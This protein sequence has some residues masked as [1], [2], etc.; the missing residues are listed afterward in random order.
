MRYLIGSKPGGGYDRY[1]RLVAKHLE[2]ELEGSRFIPENRGS[3]NGILALREVHDA[4][5]D[6]DILLI[7]NTGLLL[8]ELGGQDGMDMSLADFNWIGKASSE[9]RILLVRKGTGISSF[10]ELRQRGEGLIFVTSGFGGASNVQTTMINTTFGLGVKVVPGFGGNEAEAAL[11]KDEVDG[12]LMSESNVPQLLEADAA[13]PLLA[14]GRS[15][16]PGLQDLPQGA[17]VAQTED[18][19]L[20]AQLITAMTT[21]GRITVAPPQMDPARVDVFRDAYARAL[22]SPEL[23][24]EAAELGLPL[25]VLPGDETQEIARNVLSGNPRMRDLVTA[26]FEN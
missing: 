16:L 10:E 2:R 25:D 3:A 12:L 18:E 11:L 7:F 24:A 20:T 1:G 5:L 15:E 6:Q 21:L 23:R 14:F 19:R 9:P 22:A 13:V 17:D 26:V 8:S 4:A